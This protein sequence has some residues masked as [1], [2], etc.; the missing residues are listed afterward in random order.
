M[1]CGIHLYSLFANLNDIDEQKLQPRES[2]QNSFSHPGKIFLYVSLFVAKKCLPA[3]I[4]D[5][6]CA[7]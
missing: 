6:S 3:N 2:S 5:H 1:G 7:C 4:P